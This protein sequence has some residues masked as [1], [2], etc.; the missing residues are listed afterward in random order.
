MKIRLSPQ[1]RC[2]RIWGIPYKPMA[3]LKNHDLYNGPT[4]TDELEAKTW[5]SVNIQVSHLQ[6]ACKILSPKYF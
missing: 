2:T 3:V 6:N 1:I 5:S 4:F